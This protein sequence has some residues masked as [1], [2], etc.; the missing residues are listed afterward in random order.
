LARPTLITASALLLA[1][2]VGSSTA[3]AQ[4][5][6]E[7]ARTKAYK[8]YL[9]SNPPGATVYVNDK[10]WGAYCTTPCER[11]KLPYKTTYKIIFSKDGYKD[12]EENLEITN[13]YWVK[14]ELTVTLEK[15]VKPSIL[16]IQSDSSG[17]ATGAIITVDGKSM[18]TVPS[19]ITLP[20]GRHQVRIEKAGFTIHDQWV[21]LAEGQV[22]TVQ[23]VLK[24]VEK[25]KGTLLVSA[26]VSNA[27]VLID[28]KS[29]GNAPVVAGNLEAGPHTVEVKAPGATTPWKQVV[30][31]ESGVV[32]KVNASVGANIPKVGTLRVVCNVPGAEV[33]VDGELK[34]KAPLTVTNLIPGDHVVQVQ[35]KGFLPKRVPFKV[36]VNEQSLVTVD[37]EAKAEERD[38]GTLRIQSDQPEAS[39]VID[40]Q[41]IGRAPIEKTDVAAGPHIVKV[42]KD[43][44]LTH[45]ERFELKKGQVYT[46]TAVLKAAGKVKITTNVPGAT[47]FVDSKPIGQTPLMDYELP[48]GQYSLEIEA[49]GYHREQRTLTIEGGKPVALHVDL[50]PM[51][52]GPTP[53]E[54]KRGLSSFGAM[55]VPPNRF[56]ADL[57][58]GYP[59][60]GQA[61]LTVG[62]WKARRH[63]GIDAGIGMRLQGVI[64]IFYVH[65]RMQLFTAGPFST[66]VFL[67]VG[68]GPGI[69][70]RNTFELNVGALFTL[71]F[72]NL[73][74]V[75]ARLWGQ[76]Y[77][78]RFCREKPANE[79]EGESEPS[80]CAETTQPANFPQ[81]RWDWDKVRDRFSGGRFLMSLTLEVALSTNL[82]VFAELV[83]APV[84]MRAMFHNWFNPVMPSARM[85]G[86]P[87]VYGNA[88][89]TIKF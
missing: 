43:G 87:R 6:W 7:I 15:E 69:Q 81:S 54:V 42:E 51:R 88:G 62:A 79:A 34:G 76:V 44:F 70:A 60:F 4:K 14:F 49:N 36:V 13:K 33:L 52:T 30:D 19:K 74:T 16:D 17:N 78:D 75:T 89:V 18:G 59:W 57:S 29:Y 83:G 48:A 80:W 84:E 53:D 11:K 68:G 8:V 77:S 31:V 72:R 82:S 1:L 12:K 3:Q 73:V 64:N 55:T 10:K 85:G 20:A 32:K 61:R 22:W 45:T 26:D 37:L 56:T 38:V 35:A 66:G 63:F 41:R 2:V 67:D 50:S 21:E 9:D 46:I 24:P 5:P 28:G 47:V 71:H 86:D 25:P 65:G 39:V 23:A 40:G 58:V 27:E